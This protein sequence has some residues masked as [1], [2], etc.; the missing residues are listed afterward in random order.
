MSRDEARRISKAFES[1]DLGYG[2]AD[3]IKWAEKE[4]WVG[5]S[6]A[7]IES[8]NAAFEDADRD[9]GELTRR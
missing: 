6:E 3:T 1:K 2:V 9:L 7:L 8:N 4:G 5:I